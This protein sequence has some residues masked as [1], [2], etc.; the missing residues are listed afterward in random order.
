M[1][2]REVDSLKNKKEQ[3]IDKISADRL[4]RGDSFFVFMY[5][6][7]EKII[8]A[9]YLVTDFLK[10]EEPVKWNLR[11]KAEQVL[12]DTIRFYTTKEETVRT[13]IAASF[14]ILKEELGLTLEAVY[15]IHP[16]STLMLPSDFFDI[17]ISQEDIKSNPAGVLSAVDFYKGQTKRHEMSFSSNKK[18]GLSE[19]KLISKDKEKNRKEI[20]LNVVKKVKEITIKDITAVVTGCSEKT[21]QRDL[22]IL[23]NSGVLKRTGKRR[24]SKYQLA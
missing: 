2:D 6:K 1:D 10:D 13:M 14:L 11:K 17:G 7:T 22:S 15:G 9:I 20:I 4:F 23:V 8:L 24:W 18:D 5:K 21:I 3:N 12:S 19:K 16:S